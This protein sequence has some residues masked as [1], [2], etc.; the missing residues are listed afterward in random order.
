MKRGLVISNIGTPEA[1]TREAVKA[2][3]DEFLMDPE[4]ITAPFPIRWFLVKGL[5]TPRRSGKSA[6]KYAKV[7]RENG[8]PLMTLT[9]DFARGLK[10]RLPGWEVEIGMRYGRPSIQEALEKLR[11]RGVEDVVFAPM[12]PQFAQS[13]TG[14]ALRELRRQLQALNW[15]PRLREI[16]SFHGDPRFLETQAHA[17][18]P[19]LD[20][21]DHLVFS[22]HG[23]PELHV[24]RV[25][26][27]YQTETCC[28]RANACELNCY[29]AQSLRTAKDL[30]RLLQWPADKWTAGFQSR[31]GPTKWIRPSTD[32]TLERLLLSGVKR[33]VVACPSFV[34]DCLE[35]LEEV[36]L[37]MRERFLK[38]GGESF[39][40]VPCLN[41]D[42][43][44]IAAFSAMVAEDPRTGAESPSRRPPG[45]D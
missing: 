45:F 19:Y 27:C 2:Y 29:R 17:I 32:E 30:A 8:S 35:T 38:A 25:E 36:G 15:A 22:F 31:L 11:A 39:R 24:R 18:R 33:V 9:Q 44:W 21:A 43:E 1:P 20:G 14:T 23:L 3:L 42:P 40:C 4:V 41:A 6:E 5:I 7:W 16:P 26:G 12:Y 13:S 10:S 28:D 37:D 34:T